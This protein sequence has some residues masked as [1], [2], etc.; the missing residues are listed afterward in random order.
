MTKVNQKKSKPSS[1]SPETPHFTV[2]YTNIRGLRSNSPEVEAFIEE[3]KPD[4]LSLSETGSGISGDAFHLPGYLPIITKEDHLN[5]HGHGL[6]VFIKDGFPCGRV[7]AYEDPELPFMC[8]RVALVR[9]TSFIFTLYRP[10]ND[11]VILF[12]R[13]ADKIDTIL[14]DYPYADIHV[15]GDF[16]VHHEEWLVHS[17]KTDKEGRHCRDFAIAYGLSQIVKEPTHIPDVDGQFHSLLDLFLT[18][19]HDR[20]VSSVLSPLG[21]SDHSVVSVKIES[22]LKET[23]DVP[24]HR[25]VFRYSKADWDSFRSFITDAPLPTIFK[26]GA[27]KAAT[28]ISEWI[29]DGMNCFIPSKK[30]QQR[31]NSQPWFT[32]E[33]AA[34]IAHRNHFFHVYQQNRDDDNAHAEFN[35]ARNY[36][37]RI[38]RNSKCSYAQTIR[39]EISNERPGTRGFWKISRKV[40]NSGKA[41][42]PTL[43]HGPEVISSSSEKAKLFAANFASNSTLDDQ[44]HTLP[45]F[46]Q[47]TDNQ[48]NKFSVTAKE[49]GKLVK[50]L[51]STK[52]TGPDGIPVVVLKNISPELSPLLAKLFNCCLKEKCFPDIWKLSSVCPVFKNAGER[53]SPS[54]YR[55]ISLLSVISK[56]LEAVINQRVLA[57][58]SKN[59]LLS[60]KQYG[61]RSSRSTADA[62]TVFTHRISQALYVN[63]DV[64]AVALD[65]SKAFDKV[66][67]KGLLLKLACY[68]ISGN[69][70]AVIESFLSNRSLQVV[71]SGQTSDAH[72]I[73]AGVPQGS[74]LGPTLFLIFINDLPLDIVSS[75]NMYADDTTVYG[76]TSKTC[77]DT[78]LAANLTSD[79]E[80]VVKWGKSWLVSFNSSKTKLLSFH[81]H[82]GSPSFPPVQMAE[83]TLNEAP[84]LDRLLGLKFTPDLKWNS[85]ILSVA[86][87][88]G[89][90]V[91]SFFRTRNFL[92][93]AAIHYLYKSQIRPRMEYCC[94]IW[95][96]SP[97]CSLSCLDRVQRRMRWLIGDALFKTLQP[98]SHRRN[99]ASLSLLYRYYSGK[100]SE[101]LHQL[102]PPPKVFGKDTRLAMHTRQNHPHTLEVPDSMKKC[103]HANSFFPRTVK[104]WN[105]LPSDCFPLS[106]NI[107]KFKKKVNQHLALSL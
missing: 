33:C 84:C 3:T 41:S 46:P 75:L 18:S 64:R 52:A 56:L 104:L 2:S 28:Y 53:S 39:T 1:R 87:E 34:A 12:D 107:D 57:H 27:C 77:S 7:S 17:N 102:V 65:I 72:K 58:L 23:S 95:A 97:K 66:W 99:V 60:D 93:P 44:G 24:F 74:L 11:G 101:E 13:I 19:C 81:H 51:D 25:T 98:L 76:Q 62:L 6:A 73:N 106:Y 42:V 4:F 36:C 48:L 89:M 32:P 83:T 31:P 68:G 38:L 63:R 70:L 5:R 35:A 85:Y 49:I 88:T 90:M 29:I 47:L 59:N 80:H 14:S 54:Q 10:Q 67:H 86:K 91:G 16:N 40:L 69:V 43:I 9:S 37:R 21:S 55:P 45:D 78:V 61:F 50:G 94:H 15:C 20:C 71:V 30:F 79:L 105:S 100:C 92:T 103:F 82:K 22:K 8:F 96:G 26:S